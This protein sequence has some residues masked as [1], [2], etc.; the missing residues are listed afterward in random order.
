[1]EPI[2]E[3][4]LYT[5]NTGINNP[6]PYKDTTKGIIAMGGGWTMLLIRAIVYQMGT[7][8]S[9]SNQFGILN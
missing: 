6:N 9:G 8:Q 3:R 2:A 7:W 5:R 4:G 1:M